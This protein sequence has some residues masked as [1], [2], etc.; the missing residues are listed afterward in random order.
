MIAAWQRGVRG[1]RYIL[2][3]HE[4]T[5][6]ALFALIARTAGVRP[7]R[8]R[9]PRA[10]AWLVGRWG[11]LVE[12]RGGTAIVNSTQVRYAY[13]DRFRFVSTKAARELGYTFGPLEPAI[14]DALAWFRAHAM[15]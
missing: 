9:V 7:P 2:G 10:A 13:T 5:Y 1:E 3:G 11:D 14:A 15:L 12:A 6:G 4:L 8:F